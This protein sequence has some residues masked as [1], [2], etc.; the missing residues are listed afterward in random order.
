MGPVRAMDNYLG[1]FEAAYNRPDTDVALC[2]ALEEG[3]DTI[4]KIKAVFIRDYLEPKDVRLLQRLAARFP[5]RL[6]ADFDAATLSRIAS[7]KPQK[8]K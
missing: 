1:E 7:S 3:V 2:V 6:R 4:R 8:K 5:D